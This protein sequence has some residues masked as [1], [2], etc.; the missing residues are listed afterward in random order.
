MKTVLLCRVAPKNSYLN[1]DAFK[2][3]Y[4]DHEIVFFESIY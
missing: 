1:Q 4:L 3:I 2:K